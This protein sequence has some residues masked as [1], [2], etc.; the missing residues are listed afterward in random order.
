MEQTGE[1]AAQKESFQHA[2]KNA[3]KRKNSEQ[4]D[5]AKTN[6]QIL[7]LQKIK[8]SADDKSIAAISQVSQAQTLQSLYIQQLPETEMSSTQTLSQVTDR[9]HEKKG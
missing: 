8:M 5:P 4:I 2:A 1:T 3:G 9:Y 6:E 7:E